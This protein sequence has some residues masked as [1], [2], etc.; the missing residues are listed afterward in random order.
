MKTAVPAFMVMLALSAAPLLPSASAQQYLYTSV[1]H[2]EENSATIDKYD[3]DTGAHVGT[4]AV[5]GSES[6]GMAWQQIAFGPD[7]KL[8]GS[9]VTAAGYNGVWRYDPT[10]GTIIDQIGP[11]DEPGEDSKLLIGMNLERDPPVDAPAP[12]QVVRG[13]DGMGVSHALG[14]LSGHLISQHQLADKRS[15]ALAL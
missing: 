8:Y 11:A 12:V 1:R 10:T 4:F 15:H 13:K 2:A 3:L 9:N 5:L 7:G 14:Q 6:W